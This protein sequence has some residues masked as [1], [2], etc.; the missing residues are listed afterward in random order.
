MLWLFFTGPQWTN[1]NLQTG[2]RSNGGS[3][4]EKLQFSDRGGLK[5]PP[6]LKGL[7]MKVKMN[8]GWREKQDEQNDDEQKDNEK[9]KGQCE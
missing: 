5:G 1:L 2:L 3:V 9:G 7:R 6:Y 4:P 8:S